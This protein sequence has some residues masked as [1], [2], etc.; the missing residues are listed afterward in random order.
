MTDE[1]EQLV[2]KRGKSAQEATEYI[3]YI[4]GDLERQINRAL[5]DRTQPLDEIRPLVVALR[6]IK[7]TFATD[8]SR[9]QDVLRHGR[10]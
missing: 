6:T 4:L 3:E 5:Y 7:E 2:R 1:Q 9:Y 10:K 8:V